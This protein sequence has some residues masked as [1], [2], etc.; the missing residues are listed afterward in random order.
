[1]E[2][3]S[4]ASFPALLVSSVLAVFLWLWQ[5]LGKEEA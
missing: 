5:M 4:A 1:M 2:D 3:P